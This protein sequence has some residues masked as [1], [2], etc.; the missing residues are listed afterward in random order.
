MRLFSMAVA[1]T[2]KALALR[3]RGNRLAATNF[4]VRAKPLRDAQ[5]CAPLFL[6]ICCLCG[7]ASVPVHP[8][9]E[10]IPLGGPFYH[11]QARNWAE[12]WMALRH[13]IYVSKGSGCMIWSES[14]DKDGYHMLVK[15]NIL[16]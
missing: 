10:V 9:A 5:I 1:L 8:K 12:G 6:L 14:D 11:I 3:G 13:T 4:K 15:I 16:E 7:C 2:G